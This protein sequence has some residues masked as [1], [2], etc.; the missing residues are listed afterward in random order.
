MIPTPLACPS[1][2]R[3]LALA[4]G[5][6]LGIGLA[7]PAVAAQQI[8]R[9]IPVAPDPVIEIFSEAPGRI[10]VVGTTGDVVAVTGTLTNDSD[11]FEIETSGKHVTIRVRPKEKSRKWGKDRADL[12][13]SVPQRAGLELKSITAELVV[14]GVRG[15]QILSTVSGDVQTAAIDSEV[16]AS[17]VSGDVVVRGSGG[18]ARLA[19][20]SVSGEVTVS[21]ING[22]VEA[23]SVS[24]DLQLELGT[25]DSA[26]F[27]S[28]SG[29]LRARLTLRDAGRVEVESVSGN[30][31]LTF[32]QPVN[33]EFDVETFSGSIDGCF[34]G[35]SVRKSRVTPGSEMRTVAGT[36]SGRVRIETL[37][38]NIRFCDR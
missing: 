15:E 2:R 23:N 33:A 3:V 36:G 14:A 19:V 37:S 21:G 8:D 30:V 16:Q 27:K 7:L 20:N 13:I 22:Q 12:R 6:L 11:V 31:D 34:G 25:L 35:Q 26:R 1:P 24:G 29:N 4:V 9:K 5:A 10:E 18:K 38:G 32:T 28:V 17:S